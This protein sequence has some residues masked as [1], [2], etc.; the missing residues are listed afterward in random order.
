MSLGRGWHGGSVINMAYSIQFLFLPNLLFSC[1]SFFLFYFNP[2]F[3]CTF[4]TPHVNNRI[5]V[6][7]S[8]FCRNIPSCVVVSV[9]PILPQSHKICHK[10]SLL[11]ILHYSG[12]LPNFYYIAQ[13]FT[14]LQSTV[15]YQT[16]KKARRCKDPQCFIF[17][18]TLR[19]NGAQYKLHT[20]CS[21]HSSLP[22][23]LHCYELK[24][25][26]NT[27]HPFPPLH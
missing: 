6:S 4:L 19:P 22:N 12:L 11:H 24:T 17:S 1:S 9:C 15:L 14:L 21:T 27:L 13:H 8:P 26:Q 7:F 3:L 23:I 20:I 25:A 18:Y 16:L 5:F 10:G 2:V